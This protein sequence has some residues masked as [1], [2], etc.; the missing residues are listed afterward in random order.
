MA[1]REATGHADHDR[2][3]RVL[4]YRR[5]QPQP[6]CFAA[7]PKPLYEAS[8]TVVAA[9]IMGQPAGMPPRSRSRVVGLSAVEQAAERSAQTASRDRRAAGPALLDGVTLP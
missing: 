2:L 9:H 7:C 5:E 3:S 4:D 8:T 1:A 6:L